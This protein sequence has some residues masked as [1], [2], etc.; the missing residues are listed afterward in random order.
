MEMV[1]GKYAAPSWG[2]AF[3][4]DVASKDPHPQAHTHTLVGRPAR[5][6]QARPAPRGHPE[7]Q[8]TDICTHIH[9]YV[10]TGIPPAHQRPLGH[11]R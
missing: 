9:T 8:T 3:P 7:G 10:R 4:E 2:G 1:W 5:I 6:T 11:R